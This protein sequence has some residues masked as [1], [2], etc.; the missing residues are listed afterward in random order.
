[1]DLAIREGW[2]VSLDRHFFVFE[3]GGGGG[4]RV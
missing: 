1:M 3:F 2:E 4:G